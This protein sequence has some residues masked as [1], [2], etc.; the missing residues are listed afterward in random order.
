MSVDRPSRLSVLGSVG[1]VNAK[2]AVERDVAG[3]VDAVAPVE[4]PLSQE[5]D[6]DGATYEGDMYD[7]WPLERSSSVATRRGAT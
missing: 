4:N 7:R 5:R 1:V 2:A 6:H 3:A